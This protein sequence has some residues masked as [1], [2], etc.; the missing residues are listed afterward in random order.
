MP[1]GEE[2]PISRQPTW[3]RRRSS[4]LLWML[5]PG[6]GNWAR[7][8]YRRLWGSGSVSEW[9]PSSTW[10]SLP[11]LEESQSVGQTAGGVTAPSHGNGVLWGVGEPTRLGAPRGPAAPAQSSLQVGAQSHALTP[12]SRLWSG[13]WP[14]SSS[15]PSHAL[16][17]THTLTS[18]R[19]SGQR[20]APTAQR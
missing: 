12:G 7:T 14:E 2:G 13:I 9:A 11:F 4:L 20:S 6:W 18:P 19:C 10:K 1:G 15:P 5:L 8:W 3:R 16:T 17:P